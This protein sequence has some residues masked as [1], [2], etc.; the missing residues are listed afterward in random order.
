MTL[1]MAVE[2]WS[3]GHVGPDGIAPNFKD[4]ELIEAITAANAWA[5][6]SACGL[7]DL[8]KNDNLGARLMEI[9]RELAF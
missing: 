8:A 3:F 6:V 2:E 5:L 7:A 1:T 9:G 4:E